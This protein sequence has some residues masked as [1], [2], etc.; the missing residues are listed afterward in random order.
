MPILLP[1]LLAVIAT[2]PP[3][4]L[5]APAP[6]ATAP[7]I[8]IYADQAHGEQPLPDAYS[9]F[10]SKLGA[11]IVNHTQPITAAGLAGHRLLILRIPT[12][13]IT[14]PE[15]DAIVAFIKG[16]GSLLLAFDEERRAPLATTRVNDIIEPFGLK[17]TADTEYLH[18]NGA[19]ARKGV[20]NAADR[21]LPFSGGRAV[22]GGQPFAWQLDKG[23]APGQAFATA[24]TVGTT[25]RIVVL[26]DGMATL[27]LG[28]AEGVRLT[29]VPRDP[30]RTTY[31]GKDSAI[32]VEELLTWLVR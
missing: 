6:A 29:G 25:G 11:A 8:R 20:V 14:A 26:S 19:I 21:E 1:L 15:R 27:L 4:P 31:W 12:L 13:E 28:T 24:T 7:A 3:Q 23:G 5:Q 9:A 30:T 2:A 10:A 32:F 18:N 22:E 16:G 17:L